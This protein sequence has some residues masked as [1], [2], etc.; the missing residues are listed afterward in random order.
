MP[1]TLHGSSRTRKWL[2]SSPPIE[3]VISLTQELLINALRQGPV[4]QHIAF[5]MDGNRRFARNSHIET[6]EGHNMG[7]E[8]LAKI[9]EVCYKSGVKVVTIYAFS[10][11]NF[12]RPLHEVNALMEIAKIKLGQLCQHGDLMD[13]YGASL[14][15]LGHLPLLRPDVLEVITQAT[16]MTRGNK[17]AILNVC[18]PY[19]SRDEITT[20]IRTIVSLS[21]TPC[22]STPPP[23]SP[24]SD[25]SSSSST[26]TTSSSANSTTSSKT[27]I[28]SYMDIESITEQTLTDH[29]F[30]ADCP[31]LDLLI[32]TSG[33]E[34]LSDFMLW[35][36]HKD[37]EIVFLEL[38]CNAGGAACG[39]GYVKSSKD[40]GE[41]GVVVGVVAAGKLM[42]KSRATGG[43]L[44]LSMYLLLILVAPQEGPVGTVV[45]GAHWS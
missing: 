16:E 18:F 39:R 5:V 25:K 28:P 8:A 23:G 9:L 6:V 27:A 26:T 21:T 29:M 41:V 12:K 35:Q 10:I 4:P 2:L 15:V 24:T 20:A 13:R 17:K 14:R 7:F 43:S 30:T 11:E 19:T 33:V 32:R 45:P 44:V 38:N 42:T 3:Y 36:C 31:P 22:T 37:T 40:G 34:R 1:A